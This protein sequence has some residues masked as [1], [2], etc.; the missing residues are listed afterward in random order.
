[1]DR[2]TSVPLFP[3]N[4]SHTNSS[5]SRDNILKTVVFPI[6]YSFLFVVGLSLNVLAVWVFL[7][8]PSR[9]HFIIYLKNIVVADVVM[10]FTF[11][12]KVLADSNMASTGLRI[13][14]CR[15]S[16]VLFYLTMYISILFFGLISI[17]RCRKTLKPFRGTNAARLTR[18][19]L[20]SGF[21]WTFL[22][23][24]CL[25]NVIL[26]CKTP[27]SPYFKCSDLKTEAGLYWH[28]VVN[29]ICQVIFWGNL[30][31]VII[32]YTL[33][34]RELYKSYSRTKSH[35]TEGTI[36][37]AP[38]RGATMKTNQAKRKMNA[39]VFLVLAVFFLCFVPFHFARVPYTMSQTR[40]LLFDCKLKLFFFQLKE[41]TLFL[42][43]LNSL[44]DPLIY[45]FLC[46]SFRTTLFKTLRLPPGTCSWITGKGSDTDS[47]STPLRDNYMMASNDSSLLSL[48]CNHYSFMTVNTAVS[49]LYFLMFPV[50]L[51]LNGLAAWVSLHVHSTS[52]FIIYV[53]NLVAADLLMTLTL[54]PMAASMLPQASVGVQAF[55][56]RYSGVVFFCCLYTSISLMGLISL[57]RFFKIVRPRGQALG[58]SLNFSIGMSALVWVMLF[59][60]TAF[61]TMILTDQ[62]PGAVMLSNQTSGNVS[63]CPRMIYDKNI[64][65]VLYLLMFPPALLLNGVAAW[66]SLHLKSTTTFVVLD[67][68]FTIM[69]PHRKLFGQNLTFSKL[70]SSSVWLIIFG[71][72]AVPN[73]A[74]SNRSVT[75]LTD[76]STS[77]GGRGTGTENKPL[78]R[79]LRQEARK[80]R[81]FH[82]RGGGGG[83]G[84]LTGIVT[85]QPHSRSTR[86]HTTKKGC[87]MNNSLSNTS[88]KCARDTSVT[89]VVFPCLYSILFI[90]ALVLNSLAAWIFFSIPST[91]TFVVFLK[92]VV[93]ADLLMTLTVPLKIL[94]DAGVGSWQL[95]AI[96][97]R[98]SAVLFYITMYISI[99]LLGLISLD[100]YLKIVRPFG[101]GVL[102]RVRVGQMLSATVWVVM[103]SL[104]LPNAILSDQKP[105]IIGGR[106]KCTSMK[107]KAGLL[108]HEG[109]NYFC[110]VIFWGTL[111]LMVVCY[112]F[113]SKK[114]YESY[115]ASRS[116]SQ[117]AS[118]RT[119][120]KVFVVVGVF[121]ICFAPFHFARVP[122]TLT[123]TR[124]TVGLCRAQNALYIAKE[125]TLWL[126][127]TNICLD[128]LIYVFLCKVF[129]RRLTATLCRK[130]LHKGATDSATATSTQQEMSQIAFTNRQSYSG[131]LN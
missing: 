4:H 51:L 120:A 41:S 10:T 122:Y 65:P 55:V 59:G 104:A 76:I 121:F 70:I 105:L 39:N 27:K 50:S 47:G 19:K 18:R 97:C 9:S 22:L 125:T 118:R 23:V 119:K 108:W 117:A 85:R 44:L 43:S 14:V 109:F 107:S 69:T 91:S 6:L 26:T 127:A 62:D 16:S 28:E 3:G 54:P 30:V 114:V 87:K 101:K 46:T 74:L 94:T 45:F 52:T 92:N 75:N 95:R 84:K 89:S 126:S 37:R 123:Q 102:Q 115:K 112:T 80:E 99:I 17:D 40:G 31:T 98:Y 82:P 24:L 20:L 88:I 58:Q 72:T 36:C 8:I 79:Q 66:V 100:R 5:C 48:G 90:V 35:C 2:N 29:H 56:C 42:S 33:I 106:L 15:V 21:I 103:L 61:P 32:C 83:T 68:F 78:R 63:G 64:V 124:N 116:K 86:T 60:C 49:Y 81:V 7:R 130:P 12:F 73:I 77:S 34:T 71:G 38:S 111:T 53:K 25:P 11:P 128:P 93:V 129:R 67:R 96:H 113:I 1:M 110:Q 57:D 13:F 131:V